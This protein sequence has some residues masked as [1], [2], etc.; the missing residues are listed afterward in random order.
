M[1][2]AVYSSSNHSKDDAFSSQLDDAWKFLEVEYELL[3]KL[4]EGTYGLV[5]K[6]KHRESGK[7]CA[8]KHIKDVF[9]NIYE[10]KKVLREIHILRKLSL[11]T[12]NLFLVKLLD[13]IVPP[14]DT[15]SQ[16]GSSDPALLFN[17]LFLVQEYFGMD[18][19]HFMKNRSKFG[20]QEDHILTII[21]N[22]LCGVH[23]M[24][25]AHVIHRDIK[26]ANML[27]NQDCN[28]RICDLGLARTM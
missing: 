3:E 10:A 24:H 4:G 5:I 7:V 21:Y 12:S 8:I 13:V 6:A 11:E 18:L 17:S 20:L 26:P 15:E 9:Y 2:A 19:S 27:I 1:Q 25:S 16:Q 28:V 22:I 14:L 23:F